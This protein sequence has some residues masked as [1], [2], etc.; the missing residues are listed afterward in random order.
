MTESKE[1]YCD[2]C[3][4]EITVPRDY[5]PEGCCGGRE[6][7]CQ[8]KVINPVFC[9]ACDARMLGYGTARPP[10]Q[11]TRLS[12][13]IVAAMWLFREDY[14][15]QSAGLLGFWQ[16]L[17]SRDRILCHKMVKAIADAPPE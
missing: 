8:G 1:W 13:P 9:E 14:A 4:C 10:S 2:G 15:A 7:G 6:C 12:K 5:E 16:N 17:P 3:G 11:T